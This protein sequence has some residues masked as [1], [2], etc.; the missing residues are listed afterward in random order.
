MK[1]FTT[2]TMDPESFFERLDEWAEKRAD[3]RRSLSASEAAEYLG[4][5]K[6][7]LLNYEQ[8]GELTPRRNHCGRKTYPVKLLKQLR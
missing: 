6:R 4:V 5:S 3:D 8:R 1:T 2:I 7:T